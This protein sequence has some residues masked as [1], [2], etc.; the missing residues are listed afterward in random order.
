MFSN[1]SILKA[2]TII[3]LIISNTNAYLHIIGSNTDYYMQTQHGTPIVMRDGPTGFVLVSRHRSSSASSYYMAL[4][5]FSKFENLTT[6]DVSSFV[7]QTYIMY[8][9]AGMASISSVKNATDDPQFVEVLNKLVTTDSINDGNVINFENNRWHLVSSTVSD[10]DYFV[11]LTSD[12]TFTKPVL[13]I[14]LMTLV[15]VSIM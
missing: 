13:W 10:Q 2:F 7:G 4:S 3:M 11:N 15:L 12:A 14:M 9:Y 8:A 5:S 1:M 6:T